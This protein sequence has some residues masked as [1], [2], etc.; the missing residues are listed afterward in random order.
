MILGSDES[1]GSRAL[2]GD[3]EVNNL[4]LVVLHSSSRSDL[5]ALAKLTIK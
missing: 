5:L 4:L 1:V 2:A 3:V